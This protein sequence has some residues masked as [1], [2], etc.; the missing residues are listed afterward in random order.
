MTRHRYGTGSALDRLEHCPASQALP[1]VHVQSEDGAR[2]TA[3]HRFLELIGNGQVGALSKIP[4][5]YREAA[6]SIDLNIP[7]LH[8]VWQHE[9][10]Y[11][12]NLKTSHARLLGNGIG[13]DYSGCS[14]DEIPGT[15]D[16]AST[17]N[18]CV[19]D[20]KFDGWDATC[21][22]AETNPQTLLA[23]LCLSKAWGLGEMHASIIHFRADGSHWKESATYDQLSLDLFEARLQEMARQV[24]E[25]HATVASG[26]VPEVSRGEWCRWCPAASSCPAITSL[27]RAATDAPTATADDLLSAITPATA[28]RAY[29]RLKE[30]E[31]V[32]KRVRNALYLY[33]SEHDVDLGDGQV[34]GAVRSERRTIDARVAR[35][36]LADRFGP[37]VAETACD[38]E[39]SQAAI[40]RALKP[41][42][43][44]AKKEGQ[45]VTAK[46]VK[47]AALD[48]IEAAGGIETKSVVTVKEHRAREVE[49]GPEPRDAL[50]LVSEGT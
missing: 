20:Y 33:A 22:P 41:V 2:G 44:A 29:K 36:V 34:Y 13:R 49:A 31:D 1:H 40:E 15:I 38:F 14:D 50:A 35:K 8:G 12:Y 17:F 16:A 46:A 43:A 37:E 39:T 28:G 45:K 6:S 3:L 24:D 23:A 42:I 48:A 32:V 27:I 7:T 11:A 21:L 18:R 47:E 25:A 30:V 19:T 9:V 5:E 10:A 4:E 26:R